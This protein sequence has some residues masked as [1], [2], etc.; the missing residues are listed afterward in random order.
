MTNKRGWLA[1][2]T[3][4]RG[5]ERL[6]NWANWSRLDS[7]DLGY[8]GRCSYWTPPRRGEIDEEATTDEPLPDVDWRDAEQVEAIIVTME[9]RS[10]EILCARYI[11][12]MRI[13]AIAAL[14][15]MDRAGAEKWLFEAEARIGRG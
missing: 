3:V 8:P 4:E 12:R 11:R 6:T 15:H 14:V 10:R 7:A 13:G 5:R 2:P 9:A 1:P